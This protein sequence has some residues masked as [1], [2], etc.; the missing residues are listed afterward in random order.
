MQ[1]PHGAPGAAGQPAVPPVVEVLDSDVGLVRMGTRARVP[2][3]PTSTVTQEYPAIHNVST[4]R[5]DSCH[6]IALS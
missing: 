5:L 3:W 1:L 6:L 2:A 4:L